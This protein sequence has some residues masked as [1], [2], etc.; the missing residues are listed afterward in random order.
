MPLW[1]G[2][3]TCRIFFGVM[4]FRWVK[5][6]NQIILTLTLLDTIHICLLLKNKKNIIASHKLLW[7]CKIIFYDLC[8][9]IIRPVNCK[10][11]TLPRLLTSAT[12]A[13]GWYMTIIIIIVVVQHDEKAIPILNEKC[14]DNLILTEN[15]LWTWSCLLLFSSVFYKGSEY[16]FKGL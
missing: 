12:I 13:W 2:I 8:I 5:Q 6:N 4:F 15:H 3:L 16:L 10:A 7:F 9:F 14:E 11:H 1:E